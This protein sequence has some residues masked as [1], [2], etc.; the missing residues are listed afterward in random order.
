MTDYSDLKEKALAATPGPWSVVTGKQRL[1]GPCPGKAV[2]N[3]SYDNG[4]IE[5]ANAAFIAA[6]N[7]S[8][9]LSLLEERD[10]LRAALKQ[11]VLDVEAGDDQSSYIIAKSALKG[12]G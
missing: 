1:V 6:A 12:E 2:A 10:R 7:P 4:P 3:C 9:I 11:I 8:T 5:E